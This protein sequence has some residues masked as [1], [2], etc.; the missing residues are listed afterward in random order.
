MPEADGA[1]KLS[2]DNDWAVEARA[3]DGP[4]CETEHGGMFR[5]RGNNKRLFGQAVGLT[6]TGSEWG[7]GMK[8]QSR[9]KICGDERGESERGWV[10]E[11]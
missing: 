1:A 8:V 9:M 11:I 10:L 2:D 4:E 3:I 5:A 6:W 7:N